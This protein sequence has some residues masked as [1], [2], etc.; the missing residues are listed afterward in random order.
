[1]KTKRGQIGKRGKETRKRN[2]IL[3]YAAEGDNKTEKIYL[4]NFRGNS[5][6]K[7]IKA[8][9][10]DTDPVKMM[11]QLQ[12]QAAE[13]E[14]SA[15]NDD[16]AFCLIDADTDSIKQPQIDAAVSKQSELV[17]VILSAPCFEEWFLCHYRYSTGYLTSAQAVN[18]LKDLCKTYKKSANIFPAVSER[19]ETAIQ[20]AIRLE[21]YHDNQG[22]RKSS[23]ERNPSTEMYKV[24]EFILRKRE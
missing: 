9:G 6:L 10:N 21:Q 15:E 13:M 23:I 16:C 4:D 20:N 2:S 11:G 24:I 5:R 1:M 12:E 17:K 7:I 22:H 19:T 14:L 8:D 3:L 18:E